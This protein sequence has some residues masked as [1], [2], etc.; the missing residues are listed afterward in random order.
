M[1]ESLQK[2]LYMLKQTVNNLWKNKSYTLASIGTI[3]ACLFLFGMFYMLAANMTFMLEKAE[4]N[5]SITVL[6]Q[7]GIEEDK[8][9]EL[10][11]IIEERP[12]VNTIVYISP[13]EAWEKFKKEIF[14]NHKEL[15]ETFKDDNPLADSESFE[16]TT[17]KVEDQEA[18][19]EFIKGLPGVRQVN[20]AEGTVRSLESFNALFTYVTGGIIG[21]LALVSLFLISITVSAGI[22]RRK[23]EISIMQM[24]GADDVMIRGPYMAEGFFIGSLGAV[25][26]LAILN[27]VY[28]EV[29]RYL[30]EK[31][32][33]IMGLL[34]FIRPGEIFQ[35]LIPFTILIGAGIGL[36][37][38]YITVRRHLNKS[39]K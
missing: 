26:P 13:E 25:F 7:K 3:T 11:H 33:T 37:G 15:A 9:D 31:F 29:L 27:M 23:D 19:V 4:R 22:T 39:G 21:I 5:M 30:A 16:I 6:F 14:K 38:S 34:E 2:L 17:K 32:S 1:G 24:L 18:L 36:F 28:N 10:Y 20:S 35:V 12:E 8:R